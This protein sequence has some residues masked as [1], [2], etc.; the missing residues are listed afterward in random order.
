M[1][2]GGLYGSL[3]QQAWL[4]E[5]DY[6]WVSAAEASAF[7]LDE[8]VVLVRYFDCYWMDWQI[9]EVV[10]TACFAD[11]LRTLEGLRLKN[12]YDVLEENKYRIQSQLDRAWLL[13]NGYR[14]EGEQWLRGSC[15]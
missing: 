12:E 10:K 11:C 9:V 7:A 13:N 4:K 14:L 2:D 8:L 15:S 1:I 3:D 5:A 6:S